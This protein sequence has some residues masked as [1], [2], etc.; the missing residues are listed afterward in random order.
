MGFKPGQNGT[1]IVQSVLALMN[2]RLDPQMKAALT[3]A[4]AKLVVE[5]DVAGTHVLIADQRS[6]QAIGGPED[7]Q[8]MNGIRSFITRERKDSLAFETSQTLR[9]VAF[10]ASAFIGAHKT[11]FT[12]PPLDSSFMATVK[13]IL[14]GLEQIDKAEDKIRGNK[15]AA[16]REV[17]EAYLLDQT[18]RI[19]RTYTD[20]IEN[21]VVGESSK[22]YLKKRL[23]YNGVSAYMHA[24][25]TSPALVIEHTQDLNRVV[26]PADPSKGL[27]FTIEEWRDDDFLE[28]Q[29]AILSRSTIPKAMARSD[30]LI[31]ALS[32]IPAD[33]DLD[34]EDNPQVLSAMKGRLFAYPHLEDMRYLTSAGAKVKSTGWKFPI[35]SMGSPVGAISALGIAMLRAY[36]ANLQ[37]IELVDDYYKVIV[38]GA[39]SKADVNPTNNFYAQWGNALEEG[40]KCSEHAEYFS[41]TSDEAHRARFVNWVRT[42]LRLPVTGAAHKALFEAIGLSPNGKAAES[43]T[44]PAANGAEA[45]TSLRPRELEP[46]PAEF[47]V[48]GVSV[49]P[50]E[51]FTRKLSEV[52]TAQAVMF[53][54]RVFAP[55]TARKDKSRSE[56]AMTKL[57]SRSKD[58]VKRVARVSPFVAN[59][60]TAWLR[61]FTAERLQDA[62]AT[63]AM[64]K[65]DELF[66]AEEIDGDGGSSLDDSDSNVGDWA[67]H[68][69]EN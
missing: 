32:Q 51:N 64:A 13:P 62:A 59:S 30:S 5:I 66:I 63:L 8:K 52:E 18:L 53:G 40:G 65:F 37:T 45:V 35:V 42:E 3:N 14:I 21:L 31:R 38:P 17:V 1:V 48:T 67:T 46:A 22:G 50:G 60:L 9:N 39:V 29:G 43:V 54:N 34:S 20:F 11:G 24:K 69:N 25:L 68:V 19:R 23:L 16:N 4:G 49:R 12:Q 28:C 10:L 47:L 2:L 6:G 58:L 57:T 36:S 26:F 55:P 7:L 15:N 41:G 27:V 61:S 56:A 33:V 44:I